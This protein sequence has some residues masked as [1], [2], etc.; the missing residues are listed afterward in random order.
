MN[1]YDWIDSSLY[2]I[3]RL[4]LVS[5]G[6]L[7]DKEAMTTEQ[8]TAACQ[9]L[10]DD[11]IPVFGVGN[12]LSRGERLKQGI[13]IHR[14][15]DR[16]GNIGGGTGVSYLQERVITEG[17]VVYDRYLYPEKTTD[18]IYSITITSPKR[19]MD[20]RLSTILANVLG[21]RKYIATWNEDKTAMT[22]DKVYVDYVVQYD[23]SSIL[24]FDRRVDYRIKDLWIEDPVLVEE[25]I[26]KLAN[27]VVQLK[28]NTDTSVTN[29]TID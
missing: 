7:P 25:G 2:E 10:G 12:Q 20:S 24:G 23:R 8:Y 6:Y 13:Y 14:F 29:I 3:F 11:Y 28:D 18:L 1:T 27:I 17:E 19:S 15:A 9:A 4:H 5:K 16:E 22:G 26:P 21:R